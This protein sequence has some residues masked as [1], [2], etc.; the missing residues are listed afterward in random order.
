MRDP[1]QAVCALDRGT[2]SPAEASLR[3][4]VPALI[5][6][7]RHGEARGGG[8]FRGRRDDPLTR[9]GWR[10]MRA[11]LAGRGPW[12]RIVSSPLRRCAD[13]A[14]ILAEERTLPLDLRPEFAEIDFGAWEGRTA[15][16]LWAEDP[17]VLERFWR[18]PG[19]YP[20][21]GGE[22]P[23]LFQARVLGAW[24][25]LLAAAPPGRTLLV[26]H[27]GVIRVIL[28]RL[29]HQPFERA[30]SIEVPH[31]ALYSVSVGSGERGCRIARI[32]D[33]PR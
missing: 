13:F 26:A 28:A 12:D 2:M 6:L 9:S 25:A 22:R 5:D 14:R 18:A 33:G 19:R 3:T 21:P 23:G 10:Q 8:C 7:L 32:E 30:L 15:A 16:A 4:G 11:A 17:R 31:A 24:R 1:E 20:P 29:L 27:G